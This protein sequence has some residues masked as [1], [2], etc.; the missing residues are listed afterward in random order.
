MADSEGCERNPFAR[1]VYRPKVAHLQ[2]L[3]EIKKIVCPF[4]FGPVRHALL[5]NDVSDLQSECFPRTR[6]GVACGL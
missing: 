5:S 3:S 4:W 6:P 1:D 2:N